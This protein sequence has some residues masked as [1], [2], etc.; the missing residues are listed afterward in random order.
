MTREEA[1]AKA[2][3]AA[4][5]LSEVH[6]ARFEIYTE[7]SRENSQRAGIFKTFAAH[8][9]HHHARRVALLLGIVPS[10]EIP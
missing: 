4:R 1:A 2:H 9:A 5:L 6:A 8:D 3:E 7:M 10:R